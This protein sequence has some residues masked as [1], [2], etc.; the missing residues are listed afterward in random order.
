MTSTIDIT[1]PIT[2]NPTTQSV[3]D[4]FL[5]A[6][7]DIE[8]MQASVSGLVGMGKNR[9]INANFII[10]QREVSGTVTLAAGAYGHDRWQ[11]GS[12]GCTYTFAKVNGITTITISSGS[13]QQVIEAD[14][15][16]LGSNICVLSWSG[17]A[18]GKIGAGAYSAS[19]IT[20]TVIGGTNLTIA[21]NVG[22]LFLPQFEKGNALTWFEERHP[23]VELSLCQYYY[24][25]IKSTV[26]YLAVGSGGIPSTTQASICLHFIPKRIAP[27]IT[28]SAGWII[29]S[30]AVLL[31]ITATAFLGIST[32]SAYLLHTVSGATTNSGALLLSDTT[33]V[34]TITISAEL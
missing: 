4:N 34:R 25:V 22:T 32:K 26:S 6:K 11:A 23:A 15:I 27:T 7:T 14:N 30:G 28:V 10:N 24:E 17:T 18:Q 9:L 13:L 2:G 3:R 12:S 21:F 29:A 5:A 16:P 20:A 19:G 1:K 31:A 8:A 33:G